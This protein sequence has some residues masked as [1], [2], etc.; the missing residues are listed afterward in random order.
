MGSSS[1]SHRP[2]LPSP[3]SAVTSIRPNPTPGRRLSKT[4]AGFGSVGLFHIAMYRF[5]GTTAQAAGSG[6]GEAGGGCD[7]GCCAA[8]ER[9]GE[10]LGSG[11]LHESS[12]IP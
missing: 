7:V 3:R 6:F 10:V 8:A 1:F 12:R 4:N 2:P 5:K 11:P 9:E